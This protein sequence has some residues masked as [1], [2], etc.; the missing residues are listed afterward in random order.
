MSKVLANRLKTVLPTVISENQ[1]AFIPGRVITDNIM[2]LFEVC[3]YLR[4]KRQGSGGVGTALKTD[5]SKAYDRVEWGFLRNIM[6]KM[7]FQVG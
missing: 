4:Q 2:I 6:L 3:H 7:G 5:M 1:G